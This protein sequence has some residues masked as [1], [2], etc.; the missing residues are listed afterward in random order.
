VDSRMFAS[1]RL[2]SSKRTT[3]QCLPS[4]AIPSGVTPPCRHGNMNDRDT[5]PRHDFSQSTQGTK[6]AP[7]QPA[8]QRVQRTGVA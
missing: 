7:S 2:A 3:S 1:A 4:M 6:H 5:A 8:S